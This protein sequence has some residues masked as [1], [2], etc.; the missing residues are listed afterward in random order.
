MYNGLIEKGASFMKTITLE[1]EICCNCG[2]PFAMPSDFRSVCLN[3]PLK[4]FYCPNG[5]RQH[6]EKSRESRLREEAEAQLRAKNLELEKAERQLWTETQERQRQ[7]RIAKKGARDLKRLHNGVCSCCKR[8]FSNLAEHIKTEHP[9]LIGKEN[10][11]RKYTK[12][13]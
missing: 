1:T 4:F 13:K 8:T 12:K 9:E 3:D 10:P 2:I 11:K 7:E 6:Y 5:H